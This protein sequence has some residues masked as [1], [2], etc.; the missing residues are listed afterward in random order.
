MSRPNTVVGEIEGTPQS[1]QLDV[2]RTGDDGEQQGDRFRVLH[3]P[4]TKTRASQGVSQTATH[5]EA[6]ATPEE[7][8]GQGPRDTAS[9][10]T[11]EPNDRSSD[12][13]TAP[14]A[15]GGCWCVCLC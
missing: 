10:H 6:R 15:I 5:L 11:D 1:H 14:F 9:E 4:E 8:Y 2:R 3:P 12:T 13:S 7:P